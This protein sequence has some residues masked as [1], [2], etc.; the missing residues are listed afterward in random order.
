[1]AHLI[2]YVDVTTTVAGFLTY[3]DNLAIGFLKRQG[4]TRDITLLVSQWKLGRRILGI[5]NSKAG[6]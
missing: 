6:R 1:M 3:A 5:T 4:Y 2:D